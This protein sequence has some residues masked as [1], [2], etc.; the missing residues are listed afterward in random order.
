M[1]PLNTQLHGAAGRS[2]RALQQCTL[3]FSEGPA[4]QFS[5]P[6]N[7]S[8]PL[9]SNPSFT[10][11]PVPGHY[12]SVPP[13]HDGGHIPGLFYCSGLSSRCKASEN[14]GSQKDCTLRER[15]PTQQTR[16]SRATFVSEVSPMPRGNLIYLGSSTF[17]LSLCLY[18]AHTRS[19]PPAGI[20]FPPFSIFFHISVPG[21]V[22]PIPACQHHLWKA[23]LCCHPNFIFGLM[24]HSR[25]GISQPAV[26]TS[27]PRLRKPKLWLFTYKQVR[28]KPQ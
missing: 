10:P 24:L 11:P 25:A 6:G 17:A 3:T 19:C 15:V 9:S 23:S 22:G 21:D 16:W 7:P 2:P 5:S 13:A 1:P 12:Y 28:G 14:A 4:R 20:C 8:P 27:G 26:S 18:P